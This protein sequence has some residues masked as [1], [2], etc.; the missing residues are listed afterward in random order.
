MRAASSAARTGR[1]LLLF[2]LFWIP[3]A[4]V[5]G[6]IPWQNTTSVFLKDIAFLLLCPFI[7]LL[8]VVGLGWGGLSRTPERNSPLLAPGLLLAAWIA[9]LLWRSPYPAAAFQEAHRWFCYLALAFAA[10]LLLRSPSIQEKAWSLTLLASALVSIHAILQ[11][12]DYDLFPWGD[13]PWALPLRRVC[14]SLGNPNFLGG[15]LV[16][17]LPLTVAALACRRRTGGRGAA[18]AS[19][20]AQA[21]LVM[22]CIAHSGS[23]SI[24]R[25]AAR[26]G[27]SSPDALRPFLVLAQVIVL[28]APVVIYFSRAKRFYPVFLI[29][30]FQ[31]IALVLT[32]SLGSLAGVIAAL[33]LMASLFVL[34]KLHRKG[35]G[36]SSKKALAAL[37]A[38]FAVTLFLA[39]P[40]AR[41]VANYRKAT[42]LERREMYRGTVQ[43]IAERPLSGFGP[44]MFSVFFPDYRPTQLAIYIPPGEYFVDHGHSEYLELAS[45]FGLVGLGLYLWFILS[46]VWPA[47]ARCRSERPNAL[48]WLRASLAGA[49]AGTLAQNLIS[50]NLRQI[51][52][53]CLFWLSLGWLSA[54]VL[55]PAPRLPF[56]TRFPALRRWLL[57]GAVVL[58]FLL[59]V[60]NAAVVGKE[61]VGDLLL[62]RGI[63][64]SNRIEEATTPEARHYNYRHALYYYD[65][66][67]RLI[68][69]RAQGHY[70]LA[71]LKF[72]FDDYEGAL[73]SYRK[74]FDLERH[75]VDVDFNI[76]TTLVKLHR[77]DEALALYEQS[78]EED[79]KNARLHDYYARTL[80]LAGRPQEA[81][82]ARR[83]AIEL[84]H[85]KLRLYPHDARLYHDLGK[86]YM[87]DEQWDEARDYLW[88]AVKADPRN[89]VFQQSW[90]EYQALRALQSPQSNPRERR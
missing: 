22:L 26:W 36:R 66:A 42:V 7:L 70:F 72:S 3:L 13:F 77:Y 69:H 38:V 47:V 33:F 80:Y 87:F 68:P 5:P 2:I 50:V 24:E 23:S 90:R 8:A 25:L 32:F 37:L 84:F 41:L 20:I 40:T 4:F 59:S 63:A 10:S 74:V 19:F 15:Y 39:Y 49:L 54:L 34:S 21:L 27:V 16:A 48:W 62:T 51:S 88:R 53:A 12:L 76:A 44:G 58:L 60:A 1:L 55:R 71:A 28:A 86:N 14:S 18:I 52:T 9:L 45:E 73:E 61:Y 65:K 83:R 6:G 29:L 56:F 82:P 89:P 85:D 79:P 81:G 46:A 17:T 11:F 75:F 67:L 78:L 43:M 31:L 64:I 35:L 30:Y 57:R